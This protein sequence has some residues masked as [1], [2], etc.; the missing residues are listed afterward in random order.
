MYKLNQK[1]RNYIKSKIGVDFDKI[2]KMTPNELESLIEKKIHRK[3][4]YKPLTDDHQTR[5]TPYLFLWRVLGM[6]EVDRQLR[7]S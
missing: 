2:L 3:L 5:G 7:K 1:S 4:E 6:K